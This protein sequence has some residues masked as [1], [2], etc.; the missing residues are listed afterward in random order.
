VCLCR[1]KETDRWTTNKQTQGDVEKK[2][3]GGEKWRGE[4]SLSAR[5]W[6]DGSSFYIYLLPLIYTYIHTQRHIDD[7]DRSELWQ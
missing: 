1:K 7:D 6:R 5:G 4:E 3:G 2:G